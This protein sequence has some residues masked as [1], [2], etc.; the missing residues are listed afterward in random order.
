MSS[1]G[2]VCLFVALSL[3]LVCILYPPVIKR[4]R[5]LAGTTSGVSSTPWCKFWADIP[6]G[7]VKIGQEIN[8]VAW[9]VLQPTER[10]KRLWY[11]TAKRCVI[12]EHLG[13]ILQQGD[14]ITWDNQTISIHLCLVYVC[15]IV[16]YGFFEALSLNFWSYIYI[17]NYIYPSAMY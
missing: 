14:G 15:Y 13:P 2:G 9:A 8:G 5:F 10:C 16:Y 7:L 12:I 11:P 17:Y 4:G 6:T 3:L 1:A